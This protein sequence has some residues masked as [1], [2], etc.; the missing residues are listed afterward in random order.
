M[1]EIIQ[2]SGDIGCRCSAC[3]DGADPRVA[4]REVVS[5]DVYIGDLGDRVFV[6]ADP[7]AGTIG[8]NGKPIWSP[9]QIA[10]HLNRTGAN[11]TGTIDPAIQRGDTDPTTIT[12]GFFN[13]Q[14]ELFDNGY[15]Y[16]V[17][18]QGFGLAEYFNFAP[19]TAAQRAAAR[20]AMQSWD[21]VAA[22]SFVETNADNADINFGNLA[23]APT[24]QAYSRLP[25]GT[26]STNPIVNEQAQWIVGDVWISASQPS[27]FQLD[28]GGYGLQTLTHEVGHSLG[29]SHPGGYNAAP[30]V[31]FSYGNHA[32]YYQDT[33]AYTV[34]SYF[35][36]S[37]LGA[38]HFDFNISTTV[39]SGVPLIHDIAAIQA[40]YG[41]DMTTRTGDTV[42][43]FN[44]NAGRDSF[45]FD[46]TPAPVMAI[47]DAGGEDTLDTSGYATQ[48]LIDLRQGM[49]SSIG[50][51]TYD[52]APSFEQVNA[53]RAA[54]GMGPVSRATYDANMAVLLAAPIVGRL[55]DN[56]G[57]AYG[58][59]I[60][61]AIGGSGADLIIGNEV[62]NKLYGNDG[63]DVLIGG[64]GADLLD[65]GDGFDI[66]SYA[67]SAAGMVMTFGRPEG[68]DAAG[69][70]WIS[71]EG[72]EGSQFDDRLTGGNGDD[73]LSGLGGVD[74]LI[75]GN[76]NDMLIGGAGDDVLDGG[77]GSDML[78]GG[79]GNDILNGGNGADTIDGDAGDDV[80]D[81]GNDN[82]TLRGGDGADHIDGG[83]G[84]DTLEGG[85]G[86]DMLIG[87]N[88][89]D[90]LHGG[91]GDD[92]LLGGNGNDVL[93]G[94]AGNDV[95]HGG[96]GNDRFVFTDLGGT[97]Q[98]TDFR[99]GDKIDLSGLDA[100][101]GGGDDAFAFIGAGAFTAAGQLRSYASGGSF[102]AEGDID[103]DGLADFVIQTNT[104]LTVTDF[105]L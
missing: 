76:G 81:G 5:P 98:V 41:A 31:T 27:N 90:V 4:D 16:F 79:T 11:W 14:A 74:Y 44:S 45:D 3:Q 32:E 77:N 48:Q 70:V 20:E 49:L 78:I 86:V 10:D 25:F 47:W 80:I 88:G 46:L 66:V 105:V 84:D 53:N 87:G 34:M 15:V 50:G 64:E 19:F 75:G 1:S 65:G 62:V 91:A 54:A 40:M 68:G 38:R 21:D 67:T 59:I 63:D 28:E 29:L 8:S 92:T 104:L 9:E 99:R 12:F 93:N 83:N 89:N 33:R 30:G 72:L 102:F 24:T 18:N 82:D 39:Y 42:Y 2:H 71:I 13:S 36:A 26:V 51:V 58:A 56:V 103:G 61:N 73:Y 94:G 100:I 97:D 69:D 37:S 52:T 55:T 35:E 85:A 60:E 22:I 43:G 7:L 23:S 95:L 6:S 57:I 101:A 96:N 17:G